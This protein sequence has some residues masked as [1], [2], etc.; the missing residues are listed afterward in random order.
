MDKI[1][2]GLRSMNG[3]RLELGSGAVVL[4]FDPKR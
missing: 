1:L 3:S 2:P 4:R